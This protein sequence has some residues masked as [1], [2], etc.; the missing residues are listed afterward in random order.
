MTLPSSSPL[1]RRDFLARSSAGA[2]MFAAAPLLGSALT[3]DVL[4]AD[5][6]TRAPSA[7]KSYPIGIE[8]FAVR[9]AMMKDLPGTLQTLKTQ[10]Y[11]VVEFFAPYLGWQIPYAKTVRTMLDDLGLKAY[12]THNGMPAM[13]PGDMQTKA[14]EINQILGTRH[15]V[16]SSPGM[17]TGT[18]DEWKALAAK[19]TAASD[20]FRPHGLLAGLH[21]HDAEWAKLADGQRVMELIAA[22]TPADFVLQLDVGTCVKA[23]AD[24]VAWI[25]AHPGRIRSA[26]LKDWAPGTEAQEKS[27]RVLFGEGVSPW[28]QIV[29]A[30]EA[31]GGVEFY[32]MEQEGSRYSELETSSRCLASWK[33]LRRTL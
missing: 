4:A 25:N 1:T 9:N 12:S 7:P 3:P 6:P 23:G 24:P 5:S 26:H 27:Y 33:A 32:L 31:T 19:L 16:L 2:A 14:I 8:M 15:I 20:T 21:N 30:L 10:G 11:E 28:K 17:E 18:V 29:T 22:N 13:V